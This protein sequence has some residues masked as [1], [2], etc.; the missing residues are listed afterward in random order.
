MFRL[1][2]SGFDKFKKVLSKARALLGNKIR[3]LFKGKIDENTIEQLEQVLYEADL[4]VKASYELT[5][6]IRRVYQNNPKLTADELISHLKNEILT[7]LGQET[8]GIVEASTSPTVI[9]IVGVNGNGKTTAVAKLAKRFQDA[10]KKVLIAAGDTFR[11]AAIEQLELWA[12]RLGVDIVKSK[13]G[14]DAA[15]VAF[16]AV[17]AGKARGADVVIIDTA[18]RLHTKT[19]LMEELE[20]IRRSCSK[21]VPEAPHE[22]LLVLDATTGQNAVDQGR[23][24]QKHT[25]LSGLILTKLDGTAKGGIVISLRR[26]LG[27]PIK[28]IGVGEGADD[29]EPF[30]PKTFVDALF[31]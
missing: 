5:E 11:A 29:L 13:P 19:H 24:F 10:D 14:S 28:F 18:G 7:I 6:K 17:S 30:D 20:K 9:L 12:T 16:D 21:V 26:E 25:P 15:A 27:I 22:T 3:E 8:P 1:L 23:I 31:D 4:G 2:K